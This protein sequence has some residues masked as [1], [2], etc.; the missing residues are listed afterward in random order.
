MRPG[1]APRPKASRL[2]QQRYFLNWESQCYNWQLEFRESVRGSEANPI[3]DTD[4]RFALT[5]KN[6]GTFL[7]LNESF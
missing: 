4:F 7:D 1:S 6:V 3:K 2:R 5:L